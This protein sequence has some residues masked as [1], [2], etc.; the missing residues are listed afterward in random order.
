M[1]FKYIFAKII[2]TKF[3]NNIFLIKIFELKS[4]I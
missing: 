1:K 2:D 3:K 4:R